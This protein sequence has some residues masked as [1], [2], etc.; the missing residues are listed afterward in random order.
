MGKDTESASLLLLEPILRDIA[1]GA[2]VPA[3]K[4]SWGMDMQKTFG[5]FVIVP[6]WYRKEGWSCPVELKAEKKHTGN[7]FIEN[8]SNK[9]KK[10]GWLHTSKCAI[11]VYHFL[12]IDLAY[13]FPFE[14]LRT[15]VL[16]NKD[17]FREVVQTKYNQENVTTGYLVPAET[18]VKET[19]GTIFN[20]VTLGKIPKTI[21]K[22]FRA[23]YEKDMNA[24]FYTG[25]ET[26]RHLTR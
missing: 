23:A 12:D 3:G 22:P 7:L 26:E 16:E 11:L 8:W 21:K 15:Y 19:S 10:K 5:D 17:T 9:D 25:I 2:V 18:A 20:Q 4:G 1:E 13:F 14:I 24:P 6:K